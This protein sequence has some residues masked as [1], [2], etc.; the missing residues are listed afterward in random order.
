MRFHSVCLLFLCLLLLPSLSRAENIIL[1]PRPESAS[2]GRYHYHI[3]LLRNALLKTQEEYGRATVAPAL[4]TMNEPRMI[5][6]LETGVGLVD[7]VIKP[8]SIELEQR[9]TPVRIPLDKGLLGWRVFLIHEKNQELF[10]LVETLDDLRALALGQAAGW[11]DVEIYKKNGFRVVT[12]DTYGQ[13]FDMLMVDRFDYFPRGVEEAPKE[14]AY[15]SQEHPAMAIE[16]SIVLHYPFVRYF[17]TANNDYGLKLRERL[18]LGLQRMIEDGT[19]DALFRV[20]KR[21]ALEGLHLGGRR[22]FEL[23][24]PFL[25]ESVPLGHL[26]YWYS[27][28]PP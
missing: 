25:P 22:V 1:Y 7:V 20:H 16:E 24:N 17:W 8:T 14:L 28:Y 21:D 3:D 4:F 2:D 18:T 6:V 19:F 15:Y 23:A 13:L 27:P 10:S 9:L 26:D 12:G 11:T 5:K